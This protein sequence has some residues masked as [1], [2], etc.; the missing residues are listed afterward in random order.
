MYNNAF[1]C[2]CSEA[3]HVDVVLNLEY[4]LVMVSD[5]GS[6]RREAFCGTLFQPARQC[7]FFERSFRTKV[8][9]VNS[10]LCLLYTMDSGQSEN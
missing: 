7:D 2:T 10:V 8:M 9:Y 6:K 5:F 1:E 4:G 3:N